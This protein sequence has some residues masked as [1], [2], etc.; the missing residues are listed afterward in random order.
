MKLLIVL[1]CCPCEGETSSTTQRLS[2]LEL[3]VPTHR[4]HLSDLLGSWLDSHTVDKSFGS[5]VRGYSHDIPIL[6]VLGNSSLGLST[7]PGP[8]FN[9]LPNVRSLKW[10]RFLEKVHGVSMFRLKL[11]NILWVTEKRI[12]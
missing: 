11:L 6:T 7:L 9:Q 3:L 4:E 1:G 12:Y 2:F 5:T 8:E 10:K